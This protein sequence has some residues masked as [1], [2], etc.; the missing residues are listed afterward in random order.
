MYG[1]SGEIHARDFNI[2]T[3][4]LQGAAFDLPQASAEAMLEHIDELT[5]RKFTLDRPTS[6]PMQEERRWVLHFNSSNQTHQHL[7]PKLL[8]KSLL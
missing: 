7:L 1:S 6:L 5:S 2:F 8:Y 3:R 4:C